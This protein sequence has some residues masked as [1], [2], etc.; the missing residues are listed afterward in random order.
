MAY[1]TRANFRRISYQ[2]N[3]QKIVKLDDVENVI[4]CEDIPSIKFDYL[5]KK[6]NS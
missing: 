2:L 1:I 3:D 5:N 4:L 6:E